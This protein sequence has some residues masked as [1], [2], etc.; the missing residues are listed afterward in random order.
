[1]LEL[2]NVNSYY[3]GGHI[4]FD[5]NVCVAEGQIVGLFGRNGV[6]KTTTFRSIIGL[7]PPVCRGEIIYN[8][9]NIL[10]LPA[11]L[12][13]RK[14]IGYV[15]EDRRIFP[16]LTVRKN[17]EVGCKNIRKGKKKWDLDQ[18]YNIF[19]TLKILEYRLGAQLSG[20]EQQMLTIG[21]T[22]MG[23]PD[24]I[25]LDEPTEG[26]APIIARNVMDMVI[27]IKQKHGISVLVVEQFSAMVLGH[28]DTCYIMERGRIVFQGNPEE[29]RGDMKL[30]GKL[31]GVGV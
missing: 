6:G 5:V 16:N 22:L 20:G 27:N 24:L 29:I 17:L 1:M 11:F 15:P 21:R 10:G 26:L 13:A 2:K 23:D 12:I 3:A 28:L 7:T 31:L 19:P 8:E 14:G 18:V 30:Q 9:E 4:L 25:L